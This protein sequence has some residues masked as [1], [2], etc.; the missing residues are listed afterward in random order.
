MTHRDPG[1]SATVAVRVTAVTAG[2]A[3]AAGTQNQ[4]RNRGN[5]AIEVLV[6]E[7]PLVEAQPQ[8]IGTS[9]RR[10]RRPG[11]APHSQPNQP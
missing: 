8:T 1:P 2:A 3:F 10:P 4:T 6:P 5:G 11:S 9:R 7:T